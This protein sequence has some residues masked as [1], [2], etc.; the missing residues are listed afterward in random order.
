VPERIK[1]EK[2]FDVLNDV[3][4]TLR[5]KG[6][7]FF[8]S[9]LS[10]PWG[11]ALPGISGPRFHIILSG[12]CFVGS[13]DNEP[14]KASETDIIMLPNGNSHWIADRPGRDLVPSASAGKACELGDPLFQQGEITNRLMCGMVIYDQNAT[15]PI[16]DS[17]PEIINFSMLETS[18]PIWAL[19]R[20]IDGE[21]RSPEGASSN[22]TD[23]LT[24]VL[25][26][27][28]LHQY[29]YENQETTGF[30]AALRDKRIH[31]ALMMI[32]AQP[33]HDWS[34]AKLGEK[35][36]MSRATLV[37]H[38]Q[39]AVGMAPITYINN[40]R[41]M[42]A[43]NALKYTSVS[44]E[45]L[46]SS[47]GFTSGRTLTRAFERHYGKRLWFSQLIIKQKGQAIPSASDDLS[48]MKFE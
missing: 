14:V 31:Q 47:L 36:G 38:F 46:A 30:I 2:P 11:I 48:T 19:V 34:L 32:H 12:E 13:K 41:I 17:L 45:Q 40:W 23:R 42:K 25:F 1:Q 20:L 5:F 7:I 26:L 35:V 6:S 27:K 44:L 8:R 24:E 28:L 18:G 21:L 16:L 15:H 4:E 39:E 3:L 33:G 9:D 22:I 43:H 10:A 37:R 29:V